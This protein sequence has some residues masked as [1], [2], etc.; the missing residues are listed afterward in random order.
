VFY[1]GFQPMKGGGY[2]GHPGVD[3]GIRDGKALADFI[4]LKILQ[5]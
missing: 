5:K 2:N 1:F 3:D 4:K